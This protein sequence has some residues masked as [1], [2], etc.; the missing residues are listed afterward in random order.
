MGEKDAI[1]FL[2]SAV[3]EYAATFAK[4]QPVVAESLMLRLNEAAAVLHG[5]ASEDGTHGGH[6]D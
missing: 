6:Q 4:T 1:R 2:C 3:V 5:R